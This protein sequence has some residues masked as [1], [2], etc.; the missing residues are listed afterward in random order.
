ML[1]KMPNI[2]INIQDSVYFIHIFTKHEKLSFVIVDCLKQNKKNALIRSS[3]NGHKEIVEML[4]K[5]PNI[6]IDLQHYVC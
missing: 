3:E 2:D 4:L 1:L 6:Q 5:M